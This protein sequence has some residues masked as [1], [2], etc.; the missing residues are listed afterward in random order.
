MPRQTAATPWAPVWRLMR[1]CLGVGVVA[2][3]CAYAWLWHD[4]APMRWELL[5]AVAGGICGTLLLTG[6][7]MGLL[8]VSNRSGH[9]AFVA[10]G[11]PPDADRPDADN[12][13]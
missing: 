11:D 4:G 13:S 10:S 7:L 5:L 3:G 2:T 9:D 1:L 12:N 8:F 6:A